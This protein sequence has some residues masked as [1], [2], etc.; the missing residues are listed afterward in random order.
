MYVKIKRKI[1]KLSSLYVKIKR[2]IYKLLSL[3]VKIKKKIYKLL[4]CL[5]FLCK[6]AHLKCSSL[7]A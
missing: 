4:T 1:Y 3:Y 5:Y 7:W 2:K 6:C